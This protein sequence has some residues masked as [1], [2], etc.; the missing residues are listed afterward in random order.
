MEL[1]DHEPR[2]KAPY[3]KLFYQEILNSCQNILDLLGC[4]RSTL[5]HMP[6]I[7]K[8]ELCSEE[9]HADRRDMVLCNMTQFMQER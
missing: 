2:L 7:V 3:P 4:M 9:V 1:T 6:A 5:L 8:K